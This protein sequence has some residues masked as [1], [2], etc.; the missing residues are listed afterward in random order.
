MGIVAASDRGWTLSRPLWGWAGEVGLVALGVHLAA[1]RIDDFVGAAIEA[2]PWWSP[3]MELPVGPIRWGVIG[4]ELGVL[5]W[6]MWTRM[7][8]RNTAI[9]ARPVE[10]AVPV[11]EALCFG[12]L[13]TAGAW[14][15]GIAV[16]DVVA[17]TWPAGAP[18]LGGLAAVGALFRL[19]ATGSWAVARRLPGGGAAGIVLVAPLAGI[20]LREA[21]P[22]WGWLEGMWR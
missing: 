14:S 13:A 20:A 18:V 15:L 7:K 6:A 21:W 16:E 9:K 19:A 12:I 10:R 5:V 22:V 3:E 2:S 4:V 8:A 11:V 1:D 17:M